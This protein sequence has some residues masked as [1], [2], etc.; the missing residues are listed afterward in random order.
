MYIIMHDIVEPSGDGAWE[1][2]IAHRMAVGEV[3]R[4]LWVQSGTAGAVPEGEGP[5]SLVS[6]PAFQAPVGLACRVDHLLFFCHLPSPNFG[7]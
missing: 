3:G 6:M 4:V 7:V 1:G 5:S 2:G